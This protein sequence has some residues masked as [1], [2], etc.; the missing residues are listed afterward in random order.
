VGVALA[1][2]PSAGNDERFAGGRQVFDDFIGCGIADQGPGRDFDPDI[3]SAFPGSLPALPGRA[4]LGAEFA[5]KAKR[6]QRA[7]VRRTHQ[8]HVAPFSAVSAV[9]TAARNIFFT[10]KTQTTVSAVAGL[11]GYHRFVNKFHSAA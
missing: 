4:A 10:P 3:V 11:N 1:A 7:T 2:P 5:L 9:R 6:V 8:D